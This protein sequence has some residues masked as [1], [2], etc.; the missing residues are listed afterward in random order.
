MKKINYLI[1]S[2]LAIIFISLNV[3]M[4]FHNLGKGYLIQ[5]D[6][7]YHATNAYEMLKQ[8]NWT[9]NT[10]RYD[11]DYFNS[12]PPLAL[13]LMILSYKIFGVNGF[14][15]RFPSA[16]CGVLICL[17]ITAFLF[18]EKKIYSAA[19]FPLFLATCTDLFTF[20]MFRAA[21][22]DSMYNLFFV[23][24]M[25]SLYEMSSKAW[26]MYVYGISLG[27]AFMCK[28]PHA[29]LIFIIGLLY[30]PRIKNAFLSEKRVV[31]S[32]LLALVIPLTWIINRYSYDGF[33]LIKVLF[34]GEVADRVA[35]AD[36][37]L[38]DPIINFLSLHIV[39]VFL[40]LIAATLC[41]KLLICLHSNGFKLFGRRDSSAV[42]SFKEQSITG[43]KEF[44]FPNY[45][46]IL[47]IAV[48]ILFFSITRSFLHWYTYTSEIAM[49]ILSSNLAW[50]CIKEIDY[51]RVAGKILVFIPSLVVC[52]I[53]I[54]PCIISNIN[55]AGTGGH[56]VDKFTSDMIEFHELYGDSYS[57]VNAYLISDF[58][59][60]KNNE[61]HWEPEYVAPAEI[62]CDLIPVDGN[63]D[64]FLNDSNS[65]LILDKNRWDEFSPILSGHV[66]L[67][68]NSY[69]IFSNEMY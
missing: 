8:H 44:V 42:E 49:C 67:E 69:L 48:P 16:L 58:R 24:A 61:E 55:K 32:A 28:G 51:D 45:L 17:S 35:S 1:W 62:Y 19:L 29:A 5:T 56:P 50:H 64:N 11:A 47:W 10:Y 18:Y 4:I 2:V 34:I 57:G 26:F 38:L 9:F 63:V 40:V 33:E 68:D 60:D 21:E 15:A 27:L 52:A 14:A 36:Q 7:A 41:I 6:E 22:M 46:F 13:D 66:I 23:L 59:I 39:I 12:K 54:V 53:F 37:R 31:F 30:I 65:I 20:H 3:Y 25:I 43:F